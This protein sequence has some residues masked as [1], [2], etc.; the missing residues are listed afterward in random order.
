MPEDI[1]RVLRIVE[2]EG[3]RSWV[4]IAVS[5]AIHGE[6]RL[7]EGTIRVATIGT[8]PEILAAGKEQI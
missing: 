2:Y 1:V 4:E 6:K 7:G 5:T 8:Y 3:P